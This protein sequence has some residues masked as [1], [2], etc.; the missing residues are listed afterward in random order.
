MNDETFEI[1]AKKDIE[2]AFELTTEIICLIGK[3]D[4]S[5]DAIV[6]ALVRLL[7]TKCISL[8]MDEYS[9]KD[10]LQAMVV[11]YKERI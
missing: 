4:L 11:S 3:R 2:D 9:F 8:E 6:L 5:A 10:L 1:M 7:M